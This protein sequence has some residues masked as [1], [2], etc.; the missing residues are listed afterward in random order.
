MLRA[1]GLV[2]SKF[3]GLRKNPN[4]LLELSP[5]A[6]RGFLLILLLLLLILLLMLVM[7]AMVTLTVMVLLRLLFRWL[8]VAEQLLAEKTDKKVLRLLATPGIPRRS[9]FMI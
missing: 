4:C 2:S 9:I 6:S 1:S 7:G 3:L 5:P 8:Y